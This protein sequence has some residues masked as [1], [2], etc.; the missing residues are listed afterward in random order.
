ML[1]KILLLLAAGLL[2]AGMLRA[3]PAK[4]LPVK[5]KQADGTELTIVATGDE[6]FHFYRTLDGVPVAQRADGTFCY[7]RLSGEMLVASDVIAHEA[8]ERDADERDFLAAHRVSEEGLRALSA[9]RNALRNQTIARRR[10]AVRRGAK[11]HLGEVS[12]VT[13]QRRGLVILV[14]FA[15][16][17]MYEANDR[18]A[19]D[20][21]M[22]E[23]G[24][25]ENGCI[26]SVSD[27]FYD[28]S[29]G[30]FDL[31]FDVVGPVTVSREM[32]YYGG[33]DS[34]GQDKAPEQMVK[35][36]CELVDDQVDFTVYDWDG[37]G[38]VEEVFVFYAG[39][40]EASNTSKLANTIWPHMYQL[41]YLYPDFRLDGVQIDTYACS[42]ELNGDSGHKMV[43][44]GTPSH[45][46]SHCMGLPDL[47]DTSSG[48]N[49]GMDFWSLMDMGCYGDDGY[50]PVGYTAY[51]RWASGWLTPQELSEGTEVKEMKAITD[52]P[53]AYVIYND[54]DRDEYYLL[55]NRQQ[56]GWD[57]ELKGHG[58][59][60]T[61][62]DFDKS[63]WEF[64]T[65]NND[66]N[67]QRCT[68]IP[69]DNSFGPY[70]GDY[71]PNDLDGDPFPGTSGNTSLTD[72]T[73]PA[74][75]LYNNNAD[76][77]KY[78]GK[79]ITSISED[80]EGLISFVFMG[81]SQL[82]AP[83]TLSSENVTATGFTAQWDAVDNA[84][85]YTLEVREAGST[86]PSDY[87]LV[88]EDLSK[89]GEGLTADKS[90]A[91][92]DMLDSYFTSKG[93]TGIKIFEG[94]AR[95][96]LGS[97]SV[98][99]ELDSPFFDAPM[100][101]SVTV[102]FTE[103]PFG[104]D[105]K[106]LTVK[107]LDSEG[108][109]FASQEVSL[110]DETHTVQFADV[111]QKFAVALCP[112]K[113]CYLTNTVAI[114]DGQFT[115]SDFTADTSTTEPSGQATSFVQEGI[116][117]TSH[118]LTGLTPNGTYAWRVKAVNEGASSPWT[119]LQTVQLLMPEGI[120]QVEASLPADTPVSI[121][122]ADGRLVR[123][124]TLGSWSRN[125]PA[126]VYLLKSATGT[127]RVVK[128]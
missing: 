77:R 85:S 108:E 6:R 5:V 37:D 117:G 118:T 64:N 50:V 18:E 101:G 12:G 60:V 106:K 124:A 112:A 128:P 28:Q 89:L 57:R 67:H 58:M 115:E 8:D 73:T 19:F 79:P 68:I 82:K 17:T 95:L 121:Y 113:R 32:S 93:W 14:N 43:G 69:A 4:R 55:D 31:T 56:R 84:T 123:T 99:G 78:M 103:Q 119:D 110:A 47:Y 26:G 51:E 126:G 29:Y 63:V 41:S 70:Q 13:G 16:K 27:Y 38:V 65:V 111:A 80:T 125:L 21:L 90:L 35:E 66:Y 42:S 91:I 75:K 48:G 11:A 88:S 92:E 105:S 52:A 59:I 96:K 116:T 98:A 72:A 10:A 3:V 23:E 22:N 15:D 2:C 81:G 100:S 102:R 87:L 107:L 44:V 97:S 30:Q 40:G 53:E 1:K 39:Y 74:A 127:R 120:E 34:Y 86:L 9:K 7:A 25:S 76:G 94:P 45:E 20:R 61:H 83:Q 109:A 54:G 33:N 36:A 104:I 114:Y 24:Y 46:F 122:S 62:V 49:F 71:Y